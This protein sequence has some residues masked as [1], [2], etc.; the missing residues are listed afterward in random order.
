MK[1]RSKRLKTKQS[2]PQTPKG[3]T[4]QPN[5]T[6]TRI[7][8]SRLNGD[9]KTEVNQDFCDK[10]KIENSLQLKEQAMDMSSRASTSSSSGELTSTSSS[11]ESKESKDSNTTSL[12]SYL[13]IEL[14]LTS[15]DLSCK[16]YKPLDENFLLVDSTGLTGSIKK[17][18]A[19]MMNIS[20]NK[21][22]V[23]FFK[24][25]EILFLF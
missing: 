3:S 21:F 9:S 10:A 18:I 22:E 16:D 12:L 24:D 1:R 11:N 25:F 23:L 4:T 5:L 15:I 14:K 19:K 17:L 6:S 8:R 13:P 7:S 20:L 2:T